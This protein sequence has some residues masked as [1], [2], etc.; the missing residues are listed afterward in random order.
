MATVRKILFLAGLLVF[1]LAAAVF[2][3]GNRGAIALDLGFMRIEEIS[4]TAAFAGAFVCGAVFGI[5]CGALA[6]FRAAAEKRILRRRLSAVENE[7]A[8]LRGAPL[9]NA[10]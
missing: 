8:R 6:L 4:M 7:V 3:Y 5:G 1:A 9:E 2:A 10:D